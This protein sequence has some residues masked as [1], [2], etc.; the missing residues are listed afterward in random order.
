[1]IGSIGGQG[2]SNR[3]SDQPQESNLDPERLFSKLNWRDIFD[4]RPARRNQHSEGRG[5]HITGRKGLFAVV[6][7]CC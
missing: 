2:N 6:F 3:Q 4:V 5:W 7:S 1:M